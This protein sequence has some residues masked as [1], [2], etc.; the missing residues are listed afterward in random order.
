VRSIRGGVQPLRLIS[1]P[2]QVTAQGLLGFI[3]A[4]SPTLLNSE[5]MTPLLPSAKW[6]TTLSVTVS[7]SVLLLHIGLQ[8]LHSIAPRKRGPNSGTWQSGRL[9]IKAALPKKA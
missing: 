6:K 8:V 4:L 3:A 1:E 7:V 5:L 9:C 2:L